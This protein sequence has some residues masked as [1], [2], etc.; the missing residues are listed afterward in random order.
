[1]YSPHNGPES[2]YA[3][4]CPFIGTV[5]LE[6]WKNLT[7]DDCCFDASMVSPIHSTSSDEN[8]ENG[9]DHGRVS[10]CAAKQVYVAPQPPSGK[11]PVGVLGL[12]LLA[13]VSRN[14]RIVLCHY[15][16]FENLNLS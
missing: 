8:A 4:I 5:T 13:L 16:I 10:T 6:E 11:E 3:I 2:T 7:T 12:E 15:V 1:M 14:L 9:E